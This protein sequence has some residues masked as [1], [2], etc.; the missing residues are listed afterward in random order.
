MYVY[1]QAQDVPLLVE[2]SAELRYLGFLEG[3]LAVSYLGALR[4]GPLTEDYAYLDA[5]LEKTVN[6]TDK[7]ELGMQFGAGVKFFSAH[8]DTVSDNMFDVIVS[9]SAYYGI[10]DDFY[11]GLKLAMAWTNL[12]SHKDPT[13]GRTVERGF[14]DE[15]A[16]FWGLILGADL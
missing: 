8:L 10:T 13:T 2:P 1:P 11:V 14:L 15:L 12:E 4:Q 16:P 5:H 3:R 9:E 7:I 6:L